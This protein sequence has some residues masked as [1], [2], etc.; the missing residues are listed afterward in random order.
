[1]NRSGHITLVF[2][3]SESPTGC[4][5]KIRDFWETVLSQHFPTL[6]VGAFSVR[7]EVLEGT[8]RTL[9]N[10]KRISYALD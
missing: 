2:N 1:M 10:G 3:L 9:R 8:H 7:I 5:K 6:L 4:G